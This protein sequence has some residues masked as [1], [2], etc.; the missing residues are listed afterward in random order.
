MQSVSVVIPAYN[1]G[2]FLA[3]AVESAVTQIPAPLEVLV[4]DDGST[5]PLA[6]PDDPLVRV[7]RQ[8]N[9]G[10]SAARNRSIREA[11]GDLVA[12]LTPT[13]CGARASWPRRSP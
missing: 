4:V 8:D 11:R 2:L 5:E 1:P 10:A 12:F 13:T 3:E 7:I 9:A 6:L